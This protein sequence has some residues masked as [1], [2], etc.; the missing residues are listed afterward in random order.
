MAVRKP[1]TAQE[2]VF[3]P[4]DV[5]DVAL[6]APRETTERLIHP[7]LSNDSYTFAVDQAE[8][9]C[10]EEQ[11]TLRMLDC[12]ASTP[13]RAALDTPADVS[14]DGSQDDEPQEKKEWV[15]F[16]RE[17]KDVELQ[18][19]SSIKWLTKKGV[20]TFP[21]LRDQRVVRQ[22][23]PTPENCDVVSLLC[24]RLLLSSFDTY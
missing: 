16:K 12:E 17:R 14:G 11:E 18:D 22:L 23:Y 3:Q 21:K 10:E 13:I 4:R 20:Y 19:G 6:S 2:N 24:Y 8:S 15:P 1:P 9:D 7:T 5:P